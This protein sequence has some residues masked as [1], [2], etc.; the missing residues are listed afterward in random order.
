M[1]VYQARKPIFKYQE[2]TYFNDTIK[3]NTCVCCS[4]SFKLKRTHSSTEVES[5]LFSNFSIDL[6]TVN[7]NVVY[8]VYVV[9]VVYVVV[10]VVVVVVVYVVVA[11]IAAVVNVVALLVF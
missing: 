6:S 9:N 4:H 10:V 3:N 11:V 7:P 2:K 1:L 5:Y 8:V